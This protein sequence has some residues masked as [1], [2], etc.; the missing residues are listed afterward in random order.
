MIEKRKKQSLTEKYKKIEENCMEQAKTN[1]TKVTEIISDQSNKVH[2]GE[3]PP[4]CPHC[5]SDNVYGMS[6][7]VGYFSVIDNWNSSKKAELKRRQKGNY[8]TNDD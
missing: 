4:L 2:A 3:C 8:W 6:R 1:V 7:V 5:N